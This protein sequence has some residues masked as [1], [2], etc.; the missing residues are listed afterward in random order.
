MK[1][2]TLYC[3]FSYSVYFSL[4]YNF[5]AAEMLRIFCYGLTNI[6]LGDKFSFADYYYLPSGTWYASDGTAYTSD[7]TTCTIPNNKA[8]TYTRK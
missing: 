6:S 1:S 2:K 3:C 7:G 8:D 4:L 5:S